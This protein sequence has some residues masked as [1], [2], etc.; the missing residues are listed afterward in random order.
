MRAALLPATLRVR[1]ERVGR[2]DEGECMLR[3]IVAVG[4][5]V[6]ALGLLTAAPASAGQGIA[7]VRNTQAFAVTGAAVDV[8]VTAEPRARNYGWANIRTANGIVWTRV[9]EATAGTCTGW[10]LIDTGSSAIVS[11]Q[12]C[13]FSWVTF[14]TV[15]SPWTVVPF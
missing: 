9:A 4:G 7:S 2:A 1:C 8:C 3:K 6:V 14:T 11:V 13:D 10:R 12:A 5:A 15:C